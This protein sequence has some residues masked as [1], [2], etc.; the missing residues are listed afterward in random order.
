MMSKH[1]YRPIRT[2]IYS[3]WLDSSGTVDTLIL[4]HDEQA[5]QEVSNL[6][7]D[8]R[9]RMMTT[10]HPRAEVGNLNLHRPLSR[11]DA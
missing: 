4:T 3:L 9:T 11:R 1:R 6:T 10:S 2:S 5:R 8:L 7:A